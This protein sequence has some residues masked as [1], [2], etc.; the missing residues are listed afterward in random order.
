MRITFRVLS[1]TLRVIVKYIFEIISIFIYFSIFA[2]LI[3][4]YIWNY[5]NVEALN[6]IMNMLKYQI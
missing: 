6:F 5:Q 3:I 4:S 2:D 1:W